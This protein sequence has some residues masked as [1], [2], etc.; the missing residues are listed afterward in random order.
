MENPFTHN[1][2]TNV[3]GRVLDKERENFEKLKAL[4]IEEDEGKRAAQAEL[5]DFASLEYR[6][7]SKLLNEGCLTEKALETVGLEGRYEE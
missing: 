1:R 7:M 5:L 3:I 2:A 6:I 4:N